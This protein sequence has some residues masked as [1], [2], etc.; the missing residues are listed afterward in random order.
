MALSSS[1]PLDQMIASSYG[2][3]STQEERVRLKQSLISNLPEHSIASLA[4]TPPRPRR[5]SVANRRPMIHRALSA[6]LPSENRISSRSSAQ[7]LVIPATQPSSSNSTGERSLQRATTTTSSSSSPSTSRASSSG[8]TSSAGGEAISPSSSAVATRPRRYT[9]ALVVRARSELPDRSGTSP[10]GTTASP[11]LPRLRTA[12]SA[13]T[14]LVVVKQETNVRLEIFLTRINFNLTRIQYSDGAAASA[15]A[16]AAEAAAAAAAAAA[17]G[18]DDLPVG[19]GERDR[20]DGMM[21]LEQL[22]I[23]CER[24]IQA[25]PDS[26]LENNQSGRLVA[27]LERIQKRFP[28]WKEYATMLLFLFA[29]VSRL[30]AYIRFD[31]DRQLRQQQQQQQHASSHMIRPRERSRTIATASGGPASHLLMRSDALVRPSPSSGAAPHLTQATVGHRALLSVSTG[32]EL[33]LK[34]Y[35]HHH[36]LPLGEVVEGAQHGEYAAEREEGAE[37]G[38]MGSR[39]SDSNDSL[40]NSLSDFAIICATQ[41]KP[42]LRAS[43]MCALS[44][45][46][47]S[48]GSAFSSTL[49]HGKIAADISANRDLH[50]EEEPSEQSRS[51][52]AKSKSPRGPALWAGKSKSPRARSTAPPPKSGELVGGRGGVTDKPRPR[53]ARGE[54]PSWFAS[55]TQPSARSSTPEASRR[56]ARSSSIGS[57][58]SISANTSLSLPSS[59]ASST[60]S[61]TSVNTSPRL[62]SSSAEQQQGTVGSSTAES[63]SARQSSSGEVAVPSLSLLSLGDGEES[64]DGAEDSEIRPLQLMCRICEFRVP[65]VQLPGHMLYCSLAGGCCDLNKHRNLLEMMRAVLNEINGHLQMVQQSGDQNVPSLSELKRLADICQRAIK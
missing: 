53:S 59:S 31:N 19:G 5:A 11:T 3:P 55:L 49:D 51:S 62:V 33:S 15:D 37:E 57:A 39:L 52:R 29:P 24:M 25:T 27:M 42:M 30:I 35:H 47:G 8:S 4:A 13:A 23:I 21:A 46:G 63:A 6:H 7:D 34:Q 44:L 32:E 1:S 45:I 43:V 41:N 28:P 14:S 50:L 22:R 60:A 38:A 12:S 2:S 17:G 48:V 64:M 16:S 9:Q 61:S 36:H 18:E 20:A 26:L 54:R 10:E 40:N 56:S 65:A 58:S